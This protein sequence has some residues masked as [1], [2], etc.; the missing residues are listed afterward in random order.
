MKKNILR[1]LILAFS[2]VL[3]AGVARAALP[4]D[5][6]TSLQEALEEMASAGLVFDSISNIYDQETQPKKKRSIV[7][8]VRSI[9]E[10][11][12]GNIRDV[13]DYYQNSQYLRTGQKHVLDAAEWNATLQGA[14]Q[15]YK[16][17]PRASS[18]DHF[19]FPLQTMIHFV[20]E[21][22]CQGFSVLHI[23]TSQNKGNAL[24]YSKYCD[25][26][27]IPL[28][29]LL[30]LLPRLS[31]PWFHRTYAALLSGLR[32]KSVQERV[33]R[34]IFEHMAELFQNHFQTDSVPSFLKAIL[35][36][37]QQS[38]KQ[39]FQARIVVS[40]GDDLSPLYNFFQNI[41]PQGKK[42]LFSGMRC[43]P[44]TL[45]PD[46]LTL[47]HGHSASI[48]CDETRFSLWDSNGYSFESHDLSDFTEKMLRWCDI[49]FLGSQETKGKMVYFA[50]GLDRIVNQSIEPCAIDPQYLPDFKATPEKEFNMVLVSTSL[51]SCKVLI[52]DAY[53]LDAIISPIPQDCLAYPCSNSFF[54]RN[55]FWDSLGVQNKVMYSG[56][57]K[58]ILSWASLP[59]DSV[60]T[61]AENECALL[62]AFNVVSVFS[63]KAFDQD[64]KKVSKFMQQAEDLTE[65]CRIEK[66]KTLTR[67]QLL[68]Q[69]QAF[70]HVIQGALMSMDM[71]YF[72]L[73]EAAAIAKKFKSANMTRKTELLKAYVEAAQKVNDGSL[74][75]A[76]F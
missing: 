58:S 31:E 72:N 18:G 70:Y 20:N 32:P 45:M 41:L 14:L 1:G 30:T 75:E 55:L 68:A 33:D 74:P 40:V 5:L 26:Y 10:D 64:Q 25:V 49:T 69:V 66:D 9:L 39:T 7:N 8:F 47:G 15:S 42:I 2:A 48:T 37:D 56:P 11:K 57:K 54:L 4:E 51:G 44:S 38:L 43:G 29:E 63:E 13:L 61:K 62:R 73:P 60:K 65:A 34:M 76:S 53:V 46:Y 3:Y 52:D 16:A 71:K 6:S 50:T 23:L 24:D 59:Y 35:P 19:K 27:T 17:T 22:H 28:T 12:P 67:V 21:G 36:L